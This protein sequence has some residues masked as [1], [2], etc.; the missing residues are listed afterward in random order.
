MSNTFRAVWQGWRLEGK[1]LREHIFIW[2]KWKVQRKKDNFRTRDIIFEIQ[3][4]ELWW[5]ILDCAENSAKEKGDVWFWCQ[6]S[7]GHFYSWVILFSLQR[8]LGTAWWTVIS[9][10]RCLTLEW[11]GKPVPNGQP[12][13]EGFPN[14]DTEPDLNWGL[15]NLDPL[16]H[17]TCDHLICPSIRWQWSSEII[18]SP[19]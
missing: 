11:R 7:P 8:L 16:P 9:P 5:A 13:K 10:W 1:Y 17:S 14:G 12:V 2:K 4:L 19:F 18:P 3:H 15:R 6:G